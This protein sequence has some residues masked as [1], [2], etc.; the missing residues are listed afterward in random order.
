MKKALKVM[1]CFE[2]SDDEEL[3]SHEVNS[4]LGNFKK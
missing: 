4:K 1:G 2:G 3:D